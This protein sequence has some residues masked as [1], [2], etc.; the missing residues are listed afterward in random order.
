[1]RDHGRCIVAEGY[2]DVIACHGAGYQETVGTLGTAFTDDH[3][4]S[5]L[6]QVP[7][8]ILLFDGD[9]AGRKAADRA[10]GISMRHVLDV[11]ICVLPDGQDPDDML[12]TPQGAVVFRECL[13][14]AMDAVDWSLLRSG[15]AD[16]APGSAARQQCLQRLL[17]TLAAAGLDRTDALRRDMLVTKIAALSGV[18]TASI[19]RSLSP[20]VGTTQPR[21]AQSTT[22]ERDGLEPLAPIERE[23]LAVALAAVANDVAADTVFSQLTIP[24]LRAIADAALALLQSN[25]PVDIPHLHDQLTDESQ[26]QL[27]GELVEAGHCILE[28]HAEAG[29]DAS[30]AIDKLMTR[31]RCRHMVDGVNTRISDWR[32]DGGTDADTAASILEALRA[33]GRRATALPRPVGG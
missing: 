32:T 5:L 9:E 1:M 31:L 8:V 16:T 18:P 19:L 4:R 24:D 13:D 23:L 26:R 33:T 11:R 27:A 7:E 15:I 10:V 17:D 20:A 14:Q 6:R 25:R 12:R 21:Q 22:E 29:E 2:T 30:T 3:A 28:S